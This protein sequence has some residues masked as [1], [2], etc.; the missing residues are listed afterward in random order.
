MA[1]KLLILLKENWIK[2]RRI[3][4]DVGWHWFMEESLVKIASEGEN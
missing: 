2:R 1:K 3:I 4:F